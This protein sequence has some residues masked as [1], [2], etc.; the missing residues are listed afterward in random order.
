MIWLGSGTKNVLRQLK[1]EIPWDKS[2]ILMFALLFSQQKW[3]Q[4]QKDIVIKGQQDDQ[5][6]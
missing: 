3:C 5:S 2:T 1:T 6:R 4:F